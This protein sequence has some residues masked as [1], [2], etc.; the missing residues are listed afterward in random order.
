M[1]LNFL[2]DI[3]DTLISFKKGTPESHST[4]SLIRVIRKYAVEEKKMAPKCADEKINFVKQNIS[5]WDW[6]AFLNHLN[7]E[8][9]IFWDYAYEAETG[10]L[11]PAEPELEATFAE[12]KARGAGFYITSNNPLDGIRHKLRLAGIKEPDQIFTAYLGATQMRA[13]KSERLYWQ[14]VIRAVGKPPDTF[15]TIGD[16]FNDDC[17]VPASEGILHCF[18]LNRNSGN[19]GKT[20]NG[21]TIIP[22]ISNLKEL[23]K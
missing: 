10:Y 16:D 19:D 20:R 21:M 4:S 11:E 1:N 13:M 17:L 5:W 18:L 8:P 15:C 14:R 7:I 22:N 9:E 12:L 6:G 23:L 2:T 3:D